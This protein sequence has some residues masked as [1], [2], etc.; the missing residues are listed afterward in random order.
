MEK[1]GKAVPGLSGTRDH[2]PGECGRETGLEAVSERLEPSRVLPATGL[3]ELHRP[4]EAH[5][6]GDVLGAGAH[7][8]LLASPEDERPKT[9]VIGGPDKAHLLGAVDLGS[10]ER[11]EVHAERGDVHGHGRERLRRV[12][13][14]VDGGLLASLEP[15]R[16]LRVDHARDLAH[17]LDGADLAVA[18]LHRDELRVGSDGE[19]HV[20]GVHATVVGHANRAVGVRAGAGEHA[21]VLRGVDHDV[22][23][24]GREDEVVGLGGSGRERDGGRTSP[25]GA[26]ERCAGPLDVVADAAGELVGSGRVEEAL[27]EV[28][29]HGLDDLGRHGR[30]RG[31]VEVGGGHVLLVAHWES[32]ITR[33][34]KRLAM[35]SSV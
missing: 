7:A 30:R 15:A 4:R 10:R 13:V 16:A 25:D 32:P 2:H 20:L 11:D 6:A 24:H 34:W 18:E 23:F 26:G 17:G 35:N 9:H 5:D 3:R 19:T 33:F 8:V 31:V 1:A 12:G 29:R 14:Q 22:T 27:G 28:G 21:L